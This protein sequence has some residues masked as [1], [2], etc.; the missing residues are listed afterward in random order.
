MYDDLDL[1]FGRLRLR[2]SGG[3]GGH[4]GLADV[5]IR[6]GRS[7]FARLRVGIGRPSAGVDV[8]DWVLT[9]LFGRGSR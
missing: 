3:S 9:P 5:T 4:N 6:L 1:P 7:D 2:P 8:I